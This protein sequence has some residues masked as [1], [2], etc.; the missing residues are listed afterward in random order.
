MHPSAVHRLNDALACQDCSRLL[1]YA[2][3]LFVTLQRVSH[4]VHSSGLQRL[5]NMEKVRVQLACREECLF[6]MLAGH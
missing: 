1:W 4:V 6:V 5:A 2:L 3:L